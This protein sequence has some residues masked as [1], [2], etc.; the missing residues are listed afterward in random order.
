M[1]F[2][3]AATEV[4]RLASP[5]ATPAEWQTLVDA[6]YDMGK[7]HELADAAV[8][9]FLEAATQAPPDRRP[10]VSAP[11]EDPGAY[12]LPEGAQWSPESPWAPP[13]APAL[14]EWNAGK[15]VGKP[16]PREWLLGNQFCRGF[17]AVCRP[18]GPPGS[19]RCACC[20]ISRWP[21]AA[22]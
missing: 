17:L 13:P 2:T 10:G 18:P 16:P 6:L 21:P 5:R 3:R 9:T 14:N 15:R 12:E 20:N 1:L 4:L 22:S 11:I 8:Q 19:L 7:R